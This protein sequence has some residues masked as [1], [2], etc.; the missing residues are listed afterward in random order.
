MIP[1]AAALIA[2][3]A[4][5]DSCVRYNGQLYLPIRLEDECSIYAPRV[6]EVALIEKVHNFI[7]LKQLANRA[8]NVRFDGTLYQI[9]GESL[10]MTLKR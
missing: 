8:I 3:D 2:G 4:K 6:M 10:I 7:Y 1:R 9:I 5:V